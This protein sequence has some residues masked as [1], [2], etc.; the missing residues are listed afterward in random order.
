MDLKIKR[1]NILF[2]DLDDTLVDTNFSNYLSYQKAVKEIT[3]NNLD[4]FSNYHGRFDRKILK[5]IMPC[6][7]STD[8]KKIIWLK[9]KYYKKYLCETKLNKSVSEILMKYFKT[10]KTI[11]ATNC[12]NDRALMTIEYYGLSNKFSFIFP[13]QKNGNKYFNALTN[14]KITPESVIVFE[15]DESEINNAINSGIPTENIKN[16][17]IRNLKG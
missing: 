10:N 14:L 12:R 3:G 16:I 15:N 7:S 5:K 6:L 1:E 9:N 2:F 17:N 11:L 13:R 4:I 8:F